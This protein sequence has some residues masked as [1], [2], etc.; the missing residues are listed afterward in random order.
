MQVLHFILSFLNFCFAVRELGENAT[1]GTYIFAHCPEIGR[2]SRPH[3]QI[4]PFL[5]TTP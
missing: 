2:K 3:H 5:Y 4:V 1:K